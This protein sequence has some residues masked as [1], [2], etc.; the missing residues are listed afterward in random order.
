MLNAKSSRCI[1]QFYHINGMFGLRER[2]GE[3]RSKK[4]RK[5]KG[6]KGKE[7]LNVVFGEKKER[8]RNDIIC[9]YF[10]NLNDI[11]FLNNLQ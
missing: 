4:E 11:Y 10:F 5:G 2:K 6:R 7:R 8:K 1:H 9:V 3:E